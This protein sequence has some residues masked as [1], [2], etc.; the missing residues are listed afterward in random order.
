MT[1]FVLGALD[2]EMIAIEVVVTSAGQDR[3]SVV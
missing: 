2:P 3:K 1:I